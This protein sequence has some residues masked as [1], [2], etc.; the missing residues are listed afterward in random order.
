MNLDADRLMLYAATI[1]IAFLGGSIL[2]GKSNGVKKRAFL[3]LITVIVL[4]LICIGFMFVLPGFRPFA[5]YVIWSIL[6]GGIVFTLI[7]MFC[8]K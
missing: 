4:L 2:R 8:S 3:S 5:S 7:S 1:V 6:I